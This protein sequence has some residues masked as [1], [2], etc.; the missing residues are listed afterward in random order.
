MASCLVGPS[1][2]VLGALRVPMTISTLAVDH[3]LSLFGGLGDELLPVNVLD[4]Q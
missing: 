4:F 2:K 3:P 1:W